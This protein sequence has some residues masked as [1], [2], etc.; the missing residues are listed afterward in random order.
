[1]QRDGEIVVVRPPQLLENEF[2]LAAGVD[3]HQRGLVRLDQCVDFAQRMQRR[4]AGPGQMLRGVEHGDVGLRAR[5]RHHQI[6]ARRAARRLRHQKSAEIV[7]LGYRRRQPDGGEPRRQR[8]QPRQAER[9]QI[10]ALRG[11]ERMQF[12]EH[13]ALERAEQIGRVGRRQQQ[14]QLLGRGE[15]N[16]GRIAALALALRCRR[17]AGARLELH[18]EAHFAHR[19]FE[20]ARDV[21]GKRLERRD[22]ERVQASSFS[23]RVSLFTSPASGGGRR[24]KRVG[25]GNFA[26]AEFEPP[27]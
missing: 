15:Q 16:V 2:R 22:I 7:R 18:G 11:D 9:Q 4:M 17:V 13:D 21:H 8:E 27:P 3:E 26:C 1:M 23:P 12:V 6:G 5:L 14:R 10:A 25:R 19:N 24:A 20:V